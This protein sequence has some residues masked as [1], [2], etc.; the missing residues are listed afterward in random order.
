MRKGRI[1]C[2]SVFLLAVPEGIS[3]STRSA[4]P[5][6][7][8][9]YA[10]GTVEAQKR[11]AR[12]ELP[13]LRATLS[14]APEVRFEP[15]PEGV[16]PAGSLSDWP[17]AAGR[18]RELAEDALT[19]GRWQP[20]PGGA[21]VWRLSIHSPGAA[22]GRAAA[23]PHRR[24]LPPVPRLHGTG[25]DPEMDGP[26]TGT[27]LYG[28]GEFWSGIAGGETVVVEYLPEPGSSPGLPPFRIPEIAHGFR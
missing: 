16:M 14:R 22:G 27:G 25:K 24:N 19:A 3:G 10:G 20:V 15:L 12:L 5:V 23:V 9:R 17:P 4:G 1:L 26:F 18:H 13:S 28:S 8:M 7:A 6:P 11:A 21:L 2:L